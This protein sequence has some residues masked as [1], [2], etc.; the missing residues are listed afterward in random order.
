MSNMFRKFVIRIGFDTHFG[1][2]RFRARLCLDFDKNVWYGILNRGII[3]ESFTALAKE[4]STIMETCWRTLVL[5]VQN[6]DSHIIE[7]LGRIL[8][9]DFNLSFCLNAELW[10]AMSKGDRFR[11]LDTINAQHRV[12]Y[13]AVY[14][15]SMK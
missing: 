9:S 10:K 4:L 13:E 8:G 12:I 3:D 6:G 14:G 2:G 1:S 5:E 15:E 7:R 11:I